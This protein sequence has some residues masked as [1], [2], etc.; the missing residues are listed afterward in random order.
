VTEPPTTGMAKAAR[1][2]QGRHLHR[3]A[4]EQYSAWVLNS[5]IGSS[6]KVLLLCCRIK[7]SYVPLW[8]GDSGDEN[9]SFISFITSNL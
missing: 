9:D 4:L 5:L 7:R 6:A 2:A 1:P 8:P 3:L